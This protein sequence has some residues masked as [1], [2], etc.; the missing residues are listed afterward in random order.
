M[1]SDHRPGANLERCPVCK[2]IFTV[3]LWRC[4][5]HRPD[6]AG[7]SHCRARADGV[8]IDCD[9][10]LCVS[11]LLRHRNHRIQIADY[12]ICDWC[13][14]DGVVLRR[15]VI[16]DD[17]WIR[18]PDCFQKG[19]VK[20]AAPGKPT[21]E[22]PVTP[23]RQT[24][25][26][27]TPASPPQRPPAPRPRV[28]HRDRGV[29]KSQIEEILGS[30]PELPQKPHPERSSRAYSEP[31]SDRSSKLLGLVAL[32][33]IVGF[34]AGLVFIPR[35]AEDDVSTPSGLP[36]LGVGSTATPMPFTAATSTP[37]PGPISTPTAGAEP[38]QRLAESEQRLSESRLAELRLFTLQLI[39]K[40]RADH[41]LLPVALGRTP[42][43]NCTPKTC[44]C[45]AI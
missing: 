23:P 22:K 19:Y 6:R 3:T 34:V 8:C 12:R 43:R 40:D 25:T 9:R 28:P 38:K 35:I 14:G 42:R 13:H 45:M 32:I 16:E 11:E 29:L 27:R 18:C 10:F 44:S 30:L 2:R 37:T 26:P 21:W 5:E 39:N 31:E 15:E 36:G 20:I 17:F 33:L 24:P 7:C 1:V 41:G 4:H